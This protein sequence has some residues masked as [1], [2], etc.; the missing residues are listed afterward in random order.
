MLYMIGP[1]CHKSVINIHTIYKEHRHN[2]LIEL[3]INNYL[4]CASVATFS[5]WYNKL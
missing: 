2:S 3:S 5:N 1:F 4:V